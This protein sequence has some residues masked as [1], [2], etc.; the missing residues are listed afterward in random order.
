MKIAVFLPN[1]LGDVAMATPTLRA[2]RGHFGPAARII[3][4]MRPYLAE[5]LGGTDWLDEQWF[6]SPRAKDRALRGTALVRRMRGERFDWAVLL[7]N[8]WRTALLAWLGGA[9]RRVGYARDGRRSLLSH[10]IEPERDGRRI[11]PAPVVDTYLAIA[12]AMGCPPQSPRLELTTTAEDERSADEIWKRLG[13]RTDGQ[14]ITFNGGGAFGAAKQWPMEHF[15]RLARQIAQRMDHDVLV[16]CGPKERDAA[17]AIVAES[18]HSRVFSMADQPMGLGTA[19]ACIGRGRLMVSTDSGPKHVAAALGKPVVG[20][21]GPIPPVWSEN[22]T[23]RA[24]RLVLDLDCIGCRQR[25]CPKKHHRCM[26]EL[27]VDM[28]FAAVGRFLGEQ[29]SEPA[30]TP[31]IR[32]AR[33]AADRLRVALVLERF[34]SQRGGL[35]QW[36]A[37]FAAELSRR[38][39][40]VHVVA[41]SFGNSSSTGNLIAH[42]VECGKTPLAF[43]EAAQAKLTSLAAD[44]IHDMG[45]G[46]YCDVFHPHGGSWASVTERKQDMFPWWFR[47]LKRRVDRLLPRHRRY[48]DLMARQYADH[49]QLM[50]ALSRTVADD[51]RRFHHVPPERIRVVYNGVDT[52]RFSPERRAQWRKPMR[53]RLGITDEEVL[54]LIVAHNFLLKGV[55][56][57][58]KSIRRLRAERRPMHLV[59]V[60][61][62]RLRRWQ[63]AAARMGVGRHVHFVGPAEDPVPY[64]AAADLY[65]HPTA[66]DTCSLVVLEAAASGLPVVTSR[67]NGVSEL[68]RHNRDSLLLDDPADDAELAD[69]MVSLLN[70]GRRGEIGAAAR[71]MAMEH[72]MRHNADEILAVYEESLAIR[73]RRRNSL[74]VLAR[75]L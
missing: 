52:E 12:R 1:W 32:T 3:G 35:E 5:V 18:G 74:G 49:G 69:S 11:A 26:R 71:R 68:L 27:S 30:A 33:P 60:G 58:L 37:R 23:Q 13:L 20:L 43:A 25:V 4:V 16:M 47:G 45:A 50:I 46:W 6:F 48:H 38:G 51:F 7:T 44:V 70:A 28:V 73:P 72:T 41:R 54:A 56:T 59:V 8:S 63:L 24:E 31:E 19:K 36:T 17:R 61:G 29:P 75:C 67:V 55:P 62:K 42:H 14:V 10:P 39:H 57:L 53:R 21:Y 65:V 34:D 40:E 22:P 64:Y 15:A 66:Y 2:I 9:R